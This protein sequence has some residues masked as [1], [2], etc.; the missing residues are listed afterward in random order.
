MDLFACLFTIFFVS[1]NKFVNKSASN[2]F[3]QNKCVV[4]IST[5]SVEQ[6]QGPELTL[7][8]SKFNIYN[9]MLSMVGDIPSKQDAFRFRLCLV[10]I[11]Q[12][13]YKSVGFKSNS[14]WS[15]TCKSVSSTRGRRE[16]KGLSN[17]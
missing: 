6:S 14:I 11:S 10:S 1:Q 5:R 15:V 12:L 16:K 8:E 13:N 9:V 7:R 3:F 2:I 17:L 4:H